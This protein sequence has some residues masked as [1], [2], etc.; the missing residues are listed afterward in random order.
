MLA[1]MGKRISQKRSCRRVIR[2]DLS[3]YGRLEVKGSLLQREESLKDPVVQCQL[4]ITPQRSRDGRIIREHD[5]LT[6]VSDGNVA[7]GKRLGLSVQAKRPHQRN[8]E[9]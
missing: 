7:A 1:E 3:R 5:R 8:R 4:N 6:V 9:V 2:L